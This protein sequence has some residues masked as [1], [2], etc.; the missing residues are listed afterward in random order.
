[1]YFYQLGLKLGITRLVAGG[2]AIGSAER[3]GIDLPNETKPSFPT[4]PATDYYNKRYGVRGWSQATSMN[5]A[6]GQGENSQTVVNMA[7]FYTAL[8]TDGEAAH[9]QVVRGSVGEGAAV[10]ARQH[11][12]G[13]HSRGARGSRAV[14]ARRPRRESR[15]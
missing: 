7:R 11:A 2:I 6:I 5:L 1:M 10:H 14:A 8:A 3:T 13:G 9:P 4:A 12:D 15:D